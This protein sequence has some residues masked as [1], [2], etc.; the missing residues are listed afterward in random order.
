LFSQLEQLKSIEI[1][2]IAEKALKEVSYHLRW[3][4]E[5]VIRL[6]DGP[7]ESHNRM[8]AALEELWPYTEELY[9]PAPYEMAQAMSAISPDMKRVENSWKEKINSVLEEATLFIPAN[10]WMQSGGKNGLHTEHLGYL[11]AEMQFLQRAY[12]GNEW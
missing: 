10:T 7:E 11:L 1:A 4:A 8:Q 2:S 5:W 12:P 3:S 9:T 6:G